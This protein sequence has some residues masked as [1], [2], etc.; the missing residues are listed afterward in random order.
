MKKKVA[1]RFDVD[2]LKCIK[3]GVPKLVNISEKNNVSFTFFMN[4]GKSIDRKEAFKNKP[5]SGLCKL[6][7]DCAQNFENNHG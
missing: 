7:Q 6:S 3:Y 4:F 1:F 5:T 2:T